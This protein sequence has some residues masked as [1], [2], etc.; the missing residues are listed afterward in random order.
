MD[1][2]ILTSLSFIASTQAEPTKETMI[3]MHSFL[4][5]AATHLDAIITYRV[6]NMV[7]VV[8][9]DASYLSKPK[10]RSQAGGHYFMSS[11]TNDPNN[12]GAV[13]NIAQLIKTVMSSTAEAELGA[14][15]VNAPKAI[16]NANSWKKWDTHNHQLLCKLITAPP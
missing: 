8:H 10:V 3:K 6:I 9:R 2:T 15:Y 13:L 11:D 5:Y 14:L 7:L 1:P 12:N 4:D 16:H